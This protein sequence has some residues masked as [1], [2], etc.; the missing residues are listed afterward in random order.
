MLETDDIPKLRQTIAVALRNGCS[1]TVILDRLQ[2]AVAGTY[3]PRGGNTDQDFDLTTLCIRLGGP[4]LLFA[5]QGPLGLP[6]RSEWF[7]TSFS[8]IPQ[9]TACPGLAYLRRA[10]EHNFR[11]LFGLRVRAKKCMWSIE[12][13]ELAIDSRVVHCKEFNASV[14][15]CMEHTKCSLACNIDALKKLKEEIDSN[16][17][18]SA[19][20][21]IGDRTAKEALV[22]S[23]APF[24]SE[25]YH[26]LPVVMIATCKASIPGLQR[27]LFETVENVWDECGYAERQGPM[28]ATYSDGDAPRRQAFTETE[29]ETLRT[30]DAFDTKHT[31]HTLM[32]ALGPL[33][34]RAIARMNRTRAFDMKHIIKRMRGILKSLTRGTVMGGAGGTVLTAPLISR[35]LIAMGHAA[36]DV[37]KMLTP[38][39]DQN[40]P[41]AAKLLRAILS[42]KD[43]PLPDDVTLHMPVH[44]LI[45]WGEI[46]NGILMP[47]IGL[48]SD[49]TSI[50]K[51]MATSAHIMFLVYRRHETKAMTAQVYHDYQACVKDVFIMVA[52]AQIHL[53]AGTIQ[54]ETLHPFQ[55]F[56]VFNRERLKSDG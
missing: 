49:L 2:R 32:A 25:R 53:E 29:T 41:E 13:D 9:L 43:K 10:I 20:A 34:D 18:D 15:S 56:H 12:M 24:S 7:R 39:D 28:E 42:L 19:H 52:K 3:R 16:E 33:F 31:L 51:S 6:S 54:E 47:A 14:G 44:D 23:V 37:A 50:L 35:V 55:V 4:K 11:E 1:V 38:K 8:K 26:A 22:I 5:L 40:V 21:D 27:R 46:Y 17:A 48:H 30:T 45:L 36:D